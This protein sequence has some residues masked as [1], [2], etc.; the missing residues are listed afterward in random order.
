MNTLFD[1]DK[2]REWSPSLLSQRLLFKSS[3]STSNWN[4]KVLVFVEGR[5]PENPENPE[6]NPRSRERT[7]NKLNPHET[8]TTGI[9]PGSHRWEA[10][11]YPL[12][13]SNKCFFFTQLT[14]QNFISVIFGV[15]FKIRIF[16][17]EGKCLNCSHLRQKML[18]MFS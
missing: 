6:K 15:T 17:K 5:K 13:L 8:L 1:V 12:P 4:L 18:T 3:T 14:T 10:R 9:E 16:N 7:N 2:R 11:A